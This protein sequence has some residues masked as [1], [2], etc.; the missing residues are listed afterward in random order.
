MIFKRICCVLL[1]L[2]LLFGTASAAGFRPR[3]A[4]EG[5]L[6]ALKLLMDVHF[7]LDERNDGNLKKTGLFRW[8]KPIHVYAEGNPTRADLSF[9]DDFLMELAFRVP[10]LPPIARVSSKSKAN[11]TIYFVPQKQMNQTTRAMTVRDEWWV[12]YHLDTKNNLIQE[13]LVIS[14]TDLGD[15]QDRNYMMLQGLTYDLGLSVKHSK[16]DDSIMH[17]DWIRVQKLSEVDWLMLNMI[18][19]PLVKPG[20]S[21]QSVKKTLE[22]EYTR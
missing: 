22:K 9:L 1:A 20:A 14:A 10:T 13:A 18:Y 11:L 4:L 7:Y 6:D 2:L 5:K 19:S 3:S 16:Y 12:A 21:S 15:Q 8:N 17:Q